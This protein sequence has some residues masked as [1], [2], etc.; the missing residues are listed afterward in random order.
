MDH[1]DAGGT[2]V[3]EVPV[4]RIER[5]V[6]GLVRSFEKETLPALIEVLRGG[7]HI[8]G[9]GTAI[10]RS[11]ASEQQPAGTA[12]PGR[13]RGVGGGITG[14]DGPAVPM[15]RMVPAV[16]TTGGHRQRRRQR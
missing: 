16:R 5:L 13:E 12:V 15:K 10:G 14:D 9:R 4:Q 3:Q 1:E 7:V 2:S 8:P 11:G 6:P